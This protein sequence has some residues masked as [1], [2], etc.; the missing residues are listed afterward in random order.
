MWLGYDLERATVFKAWQ[1]PPGKPG[2]TKSGFTTRSTGTTWFD[3]AS[4][5]AW[6][7]RRKEQTLPLAIRYLGCSQRTDHIELRWELRHEAGTLNLFERIPLAA[8]KDKSRVVRE[9]RVEN[10]GHGRV[11]TFA[12]LPFLR[13]GSCPP[14]KTSPRRHSPARDG[15]ISHYH[16]ARR[17]HVGLSR[18]CSS[19]FTRPSE[20][21][22][23]R[24]RSIFLRHGSCRRDQ[25]CLPVK[26]LRS[27][28][29]EGRS[30]AGMCR[31]SNPKRSRSR[32]SMRA[33]AARSGVSTLLRR[34]R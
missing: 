33:K 14:I 28:G 19:W 29:G 16:E 17:S 24:T 23:R 30:S 7:L 9:L 22:S 27:L 13:R 20:Q 3:D 18:F 15:I 21:P 6:E 32:S 11:V 10:V 26:Y 5:A 1:A 12:P 31:R 4:N 8:T 2:L 25:T 34:Y